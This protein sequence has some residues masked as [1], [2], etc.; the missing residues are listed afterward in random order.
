[1]ENEQIIAFFSPEEYR[2]R[3]KDFLDMG[4]PEGSFNKIMKNLELNTPQFC[5]EK[6]IDRNVKA[7]FYTVEAYEKVGNYLEAKNNTPHKQ[8]MRVY[9]ENRNLKQALER[10]Q[11]EYER[12]LLEERNRTNEE[13]R[14]KLDIIDER[15]KLKNEKL[16][17]EFKKANEIDEAVKKAMKET[18]EKVKAEMNSE[19]NK[20]K[21]DYEE[22]QKNSFE[23]IGENLELQKKVDEYKNR[24]RFQKFLAFILN[25]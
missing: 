21:N 24:S 20:I 18:E 5:M 8:A 19:I 4:V 9:E 16:L 14:E 25:K 11:N 13:R 2:Y 12:Q 15:D 10:I 6:T 7:K 22:L 3:R 23:T 1:M 17:Y